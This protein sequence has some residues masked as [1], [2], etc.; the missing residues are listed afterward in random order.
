[1]KNGDAVQIIVGLSVPSVR[2]EFE[3]LL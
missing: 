1:M 2:S 3:K